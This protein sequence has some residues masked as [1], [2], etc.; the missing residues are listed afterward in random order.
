VLVDDGV[1]PNSDACTAPVN[2]A[3]LAGKFALIDRGNCTFVV[4]VKFAQ[5]AGAVGAIVANNVAGSPIVMGGTDA[6]I[7]IPAMMISLD[8]GAK[9]KGANSPV[10]VH[11]R[12]DASIDLDGTI[13]EGII[14]HE[15]FHYVSNRLVGNANGLSNNQGQGMG[16]G[17]SDFSA[18]VLQVRGSDAKVATNADWAGAYAVGEYVTGKEYFGIR[19]APYSTDFAKNPLTFKHIQNGVALPAGVPYAFGQDG[20]NNAE[21]HNTG[22]VWCNVLWE[23]Y[24]GFLREGR[25][26]ALHTM[27]KVQNYVIAGLKMT[28]N[29]PTLLE[30]RDGI[31]A[32]ADATD[33]AD[34]MIW[35]TAFAKRGMGVGAIGPSRNSTDNVGVTESYVV[36][37]P[38][39]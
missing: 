23:A 32:A 33:D 4:K 7:T 30:A 18:M 28:P 13:D 22:E 27:Q 25:T 26:N 17:W 21:V 19:R 29:A 24:A 1:A 9:I 2:A 11:M 39:P 20:A 6:S 12:R 35:A 36:A 10:T 31:L 14:A 38:K 34:F 5:D 8:D 15:F 16:E 37:S 3:A